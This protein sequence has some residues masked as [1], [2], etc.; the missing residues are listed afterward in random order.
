MASPAAR[1]S[2]CRAPDDEGSFSR[3]DGEETMISCIE[4]LMSSNMLTT[5]MLYKGRHLPED[6]VHIVLLY[7]VCVCRIGAHSVNS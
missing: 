1:A 6:V 5:K 2:G 3:K 4:D 7:A